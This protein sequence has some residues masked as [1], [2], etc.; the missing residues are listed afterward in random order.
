MTYA[1]R[2]FHAALAL[3]IGILLILFVLEPARLLPGRAARSVRAFTMTGWARWMLVALGLERKVEGGE[4]RGSRLYVAN[5]I[6][7]VD[8]LVLMATQKGVFVAKSELETW[9]LIGW[10]CRRTGTLFLRRGSACAL[11]EKIATISRKLIDQESVICF[12]EGTTT[13]G[14]TVRIFYPGLFQAAIDAG[15]VVQPIALSYLESGFPSRAVPFIGSDDFLSHFRRML[16]ARKVTAQISFLPIVYP[17][18]KDRREIAQVARSLIC[19]KIAGLN[20]SQI[21]SIA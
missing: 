6:S 19:D 3:V 16:K 15:V 1:F 2:I 21:E 9:P 5:H 18:L 11:G 17:E 7:W 12:P 20:T 13:G 14:D 8:I 10:M 4:T